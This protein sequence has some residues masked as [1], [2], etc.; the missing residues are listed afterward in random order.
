MDGLGESLGR[1]EGQFVEQLAPLAED[2]AQQARHGEDHMAVWDRGEQ[3][4]TEPADP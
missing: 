2:A 4:L 3:R 1:G